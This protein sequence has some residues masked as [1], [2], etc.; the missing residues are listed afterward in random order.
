MPLTPNRHHL[1]Y[2]LCFLA[3]LSVGGA[4]EDLPA[5]TGLG[6]LNGASNTSTVHGVSANGIFICGESLSSKGTA[7]F[8]WSEAKG[9]TSLGDLPNSPFKGITR[10]LSDNG[11]YA[12][13][14]G[15]IGLSNIRAA[16]WVIGSNPTNIGSLNSTGFK[17]SDGRGI[18]DN[19]RKIVGTST[20]S[21]GPRA[22]LWSSTS[23]GN[24]G[25]MK[26]LGIVTTGQEMFSVAHAVTGDGGTVVGSSTFVN[27]EEITN[28]GE[29]PITVITQETEAFF[30]TAATRIQGLGDLPGG[31]LSSEAFAITDDATVI[32]GA[33]ESDEGIEGVIWTNDEITSVGDLPGGDT[34]CRLLDVSESGEQA[35][36]EASDDSGKVAAIWDSA[37]GLRKLSDVLIARGID[38]SGWTLNSV[39]GISAD[40]AVISGNGTNPAGEPEG[41]RVSNA[42]SLFDP[43]APDAQLS[44][45]VGRTISIPTQAGNIYQIE[46]SQN[47]GDWSPLGASHS[48]L[49]ASNDSVYAVIDPDNSASRF[50]RVKLLDGSQLSTPPS[51][52]MA[53]GAVLSFPSVP[54]FFY[55]LEGSSDLDNWENV[56]PVMDTSADTAAL[57][58]AIPDSASADGSP[59]FYRLT[60]DNEG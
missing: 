40:A 31:N 53:D 44:I 1:L 48:T 33:G 6:H 8:L 45:E 2:L 39:E 49:G 9:M 19:G 12:A 18:S 3:P 15:T 34:L 58:H 22:F 52:S 50:Y 24:K 23:G 36:G 28:P 13:G 35:V 10:A 42:L 14:L 30:W 47:L 51:L 56:L 54:G 46:V 26:D 20:S 37:N 55:R 27:T 16:R 32:V 25:T 59:R 57:E 43:P 60:V 11:T 5:F 38:I 17:F 29:D 4:T 41:W 7:G 21:K